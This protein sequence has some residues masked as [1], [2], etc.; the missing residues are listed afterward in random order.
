MAYSYDEMQGEPSDPMD[1][2]ADSGHNQSH[3]PGRAG[4]KTADVTPLPGERSMGSGETAAAAPY[5]TGAAKDPKVI[6][7]GMPTLKA[8]AGRKK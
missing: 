3:N 7:I 5:A 8:W 6:S 1:H 4:M 2:E